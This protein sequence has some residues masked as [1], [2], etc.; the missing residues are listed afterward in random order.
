MEIKMKKIIT[1]LSIS[2]LILSGCSDSREYNKEAD[3][4]CEAEM[5]TTANLNELLL[6]A[7][8]SD[9]SPSTIKKI[10]KKGASPN[11]TVGE[12]ELPIICFAK[13]PNA[14]KAVY[15]ADPQH[16]EKDGPLVLIEHA[17]RHLP[18]F[19]CQS[20]ELCDM[21][22]ELELDNV[23]YNSQ[24]YVSSVQDGTTTNL[25]REKVKNY[26]VNLKDQKSRSPLFYAQNK[27]MVD[28]WL[29]KGNKINATDANG[30]S[31]LTYA[32]SNSETCTADWL[33]FL[34][35]KGSDVNL[36]AEQ[37][38]STPLAR[39]LQCNR[40]KDIIELLISKGAKV[41][42]IKNTSNLFFYVQN[43]E[44][45]A[46]LQQKGL[47]AD[48]TTE[49]GFYFRSGGVK[50]IAKTP[51]AKAIANRKS[52]ETV[53]ALMDA[54][55]KIEDADFE[56]KGGKVSALYF[57]TLILKNSELTNFLLKNG[58]E[59]S[60]DIE[61]VFSHFIENEN[62]K[63]LSKFL[64]LGV[65]PKSGKNLDK[66]FNILLE[67]ADTANLEKVLQAGYNVNKYEIG[68]YLNKT[69]HNAHAIFNLLISYGYDVNKRNQSGNNVL[70]KILSNFSDIN[71]GNVSPDAF[72]KIVKN[73]SSLKDKGYS[74]NKLQQIVSVAN[75]RPEI[76]N[77]FLDN[78]PSVDSRII[79]DILKKI[80]ES[81]S[82]VPETT[83]ISLIN[84]TDNFN[85][86]VNGKTMIGSALE[87]D[88]ISLDIIKAIAE[89]MYFPAVQTTYEYNKN[90]NPIEI[91][92]KLNLDDIAQYLQSRCQLIIKRKN[93]SPTIYGVI[94]LGMNKREYE[95]TI[96][97]LQNDGNYLDSGYFTTFFDENE[98]LAALQCNKR[99]SIDEICA[100]LK[101]QKNQFKVEPYSNHTLQAD[102][103]TIIKPQYEF[104]LYTYHSNNYIINFTNDEFS[105]VD[106]NSKNE[107][108]PY[109]NNG[110]YN[111]K[112]IDKY[113][114][115]KIFENKEL[116]DNDASRNLIKTLLDDGWEIRS[117][118]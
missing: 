4:K 114:V 80:F 48:V 18:L 33:A 2:A 27:T 52:I 7:L 94:Y 93:G 60:F 106:I 17:S 34:I 29:S 59:K 96:K 100:M 54:G 97:Y 55:A 14:M 43:A 70:D 35:S 78:C 6:Y 69:D 68:E 98:K 9:A 76:L 63:M 56:Y 23:D 11:C 118:R 109:K 89:K 28:Y 107:N 117:S 87:Y 40:G 42:N 67:N 47:S 110:I 112:F 77:A 3:K 39:A 44:Q 72:V 111:I 36:G 88:S 32:I 37:G 104:L 105:I 85:D 53:K 95:N 79:R 57:S 15:N 8:K 65:I 102:Y 10:I 75:L 71:L 46:F 99:I 73:T 66:L 74:K 92:K 81:A 13:S 19:Y 113:R 20:P 24:A 38:Y 50:Y 86:A 101:M 16:S 49:N 30:D 83:I 116:K 108:S 45:V 25:T 51:L 84:H 21:Y 26:L 115:I 12:K 41:E 91:A 64:A 22:I 58:G 90:Q 103:Y 61:R 82:T 62:H 31:V 1:L 5:K